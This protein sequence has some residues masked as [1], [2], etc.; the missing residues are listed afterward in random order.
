MTSL[1]QP[2]L[3]DPAQA[4]YVRVAVERGM[5]RVG[6]GA[7][8]L[9]YRLDPPLDAE[10]GQRVEV[11]LGRG[12]R[13]TP[14][15]V[16]ARGGAELLEGLD[17]DRVKA[18][19][20]ATQA[21]LPESLLDLARWMANYYVAPLGMVLATMMPAAVKRQT[22][23]RTREMLTRVPADRERTILEETKLSP[24]A[25]D[26]WEKLQSIERD[27][28]PI[29]PGTLVTRLELPSVAPINRLVRAGLL[30]TV[31]RRVIVTPPAVWSRY[32]V[33]SAGTAKPDII[34]TRAQQ[35]I[36]DAVDTDAEAGRFA[37]HLIRGITGSGKTEVY[38]RAIERVLA[39]EQA[40]IV[41]V[42]EIAL[43][44]QTAG[45]FLDRFAR[46]GVAVLH[47]GLTASERN[48]QWALAASGDARVVVGARSAVFA[49]VR[50]LG[51]IVVDE[52]HDTSYKQ[53]QA[54]RYHGRDVAIKRAHIEGCP[55]VLGSATPALESWANATSPRPRYRLWELEERV[56]GGALPSVEIADMTREL[57]ATRQAG[58]RGRLE[59]PLLGHSLRSAL[60]ETLAAD[61]Q[62]ILLLNRRGFAS[63][64][65][66]PNSSCGWTMRCEDCDANMVVH[67]G[68]QLPVGRLLRCHHCLAETLVPARC[69][70]CSR[71]ATSLGMGTQRAER[72]I[73]TEFGPGTPHP[74]VLGETFLRLDSDS[75]RKAEDYFAAL[76]RFAKGE[77]KVLLGTQMIAK[78]LDYPNVRLVG[79]ISADTGLAI[80]DFRAWER[81]FQLIS[82]VAGRAG[83][84]SDPGR[85]I[86][87]TFQP[88]APVIRHAAAHDY[89]AFAEAELDDRRRAGWPP[90]RRMA[91]L[92]TRD[93][94]H[95]RAS[96]AA[97]H[98]AEALRDEAD[99]RVEIIGPAPCVISRISGHH[100]FEIQLLAPSPA[101]LHKPLA[102]LRARGL[103]KSDAR[104]AI[105]V[106]PVSLL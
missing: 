33:E 35:A 15:I 62:A 44:P 41:L 37:V 88:N 77:V 50:R 3:P 66:C 17:P 70:L 86:V 23:A 75:M 27:A 9:T 61:G 98:L 81:T 14:G 28:F 48:R 84:G 99:D 100:R 63:L 43:T 10:L 20:H 80:P 12:D 93:E 72:E 21:R 57:R 104:T 78:G 94:D 32:R 92:V 45:R 16:V 102:A 103:V 67:V 2:D 90:A 4:T 13:R 19:T 47:S 58:A 69:P 7:P 105:D 60:A 73:E 106:D 6:D 36:I 89:R 91:R 96:G 11:P 68:E 22:G 8:E 24:T 82:Q 74:L 30:E 29:E 40:A 56:G 95:D 59:P 76:A 87:Q 39:R 65:A 42:P 54:P 71:P 34:P 53:D 85:V 38:L 97:E 1:F 83:R 49:P 79:V 18:V 101:S 5:D 26:A 31:E 51:L 55:I 46:P 25:A 52:E 64:V